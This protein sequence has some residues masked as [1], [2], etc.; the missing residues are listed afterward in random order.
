MAGDH[1]SQ[2]VELANNFTTGF[3][4]LWQ[5]GITALLEKSI[6]NYERK[7]IKQVSNTKEDLEKLKIK[8]SENSAVMVDIEAFVSIST[9]HSS[10]KGSRF[11]HARYITGR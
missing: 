11:L 9:V 4:R 10:Q 5:R 1:P 3:P 2:L 7:T 8:K 6:V